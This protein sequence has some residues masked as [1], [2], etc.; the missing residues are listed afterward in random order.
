M[1]YRSLA[2]GLFSAC[3]ALWIAASAAQAAPPSAAGLGASSDGPPLLLRVGNGCGW[4]YACPP[5]P[6]YGRPR[7]PRGNGN[8]YIHNNY[9][10]VTVYRGGPPRSERP[11]AYGGGCPG[12]DCAGT[13][14]DCG[15]FC[16]MRRIRGG[17][18][19]HGCWA[20]KEWQRLQAEE[21]A[22][23]AEEDREAE[24][25]E[26]SER[27]LRMYEQAQGCATF[28]CRRGYYESAPPSPPPSYYGEGYDSERRY[29]R[30]P[31][32]GNRAPPPDVHYYRE[33]DRSTPPPDGER[34]RFDG[35]SYPPK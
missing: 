29:Y 24:E 31:P 6:G 35:P 28:Y 4:D 9:G 13:G 8:V 17:W 20:Y 11:P 23:R 15:A 12:G 16:W 10:P 2:L 5:E 1:K 18:C 22:R 34:H 26:R 3:C 25:R 19:G 14:G 33:R 21:E 7:H 32:P 30:E 27:R